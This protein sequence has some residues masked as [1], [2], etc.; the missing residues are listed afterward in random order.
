[1]DKLNSFEL[2]TIL[3][4]NNIFLNYLNEFSRNNIINESSS[5]NLAYVIY[6]SGTTGVPKGVII[7]I[8]NIVS[9]IFSLIKKLYS[10]KREKFQNVLQLSNY[11]FD[12][13]IQDILFALFYGSKLVLPDNEISL[14]KENLDI[15]IINKK[16]SF[17]NITPSNLKRIKFFTNFNLE[18]L[19]V[20]GEKLK[21]SFYIDL[22][23]KINNDCKIINIYGLT[24]TTVFFSINSNMLENVP[25]NIG[26]PLN[27]YNQFCKINTKILK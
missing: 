16:I 21:Y 3:I 6:T 26:K 17:L 11:V 2:E 14:N 7:E 12:I 22:K 23:K 13:S 20:G 25:I 9:Y 5:N 4:D 19:L 24:E 10:F 8:K 27:N 18:Y 15:L 1:M